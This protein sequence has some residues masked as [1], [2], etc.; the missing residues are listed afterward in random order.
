MTESFQMQALL[1][2]VGQAVIATDPAG[3]VTYWNPAAEA[4]YGWSADEALGCLVIDLVVPTQTQEEAAGVVAALAAGDSWSGDFPLRRKDGS[5]FHALVTDTPV[6]GVDGE[7][8]GI[9]GVSTDITARKAAEQQAR[10]LAAIVESCAD[11]I[12]SADLDGIITSWNQGAVDLYGCT[13]DEAIGKHVRQLAPPEL[14]SEVTSVLASAARGQTTSG[15]ET[16][17]WRKDGTRVDVSLTVSPVRDESGVV[18][19]S[20]AI[21]R[22]VSGCRALQ[23]DIERQVLYDRL[24]GLPNRAVLDD[25][26]SHAV[27]RSDGA[28]TA[29]AVMFVDLD[30]FKNLNNA[31]GHATGDLVLVEVAKRLTAAVRP[32]DT[33]ARFGGDEFVVICEGADAAVAERVAKRALEALH[34]PIEVDG[35][36]MYVTASVGI[37]TAPPLDAERL[38]RRADAAMYDAK[39]RGGARASLFDESLGERADEELTLSTDL[40]QAIELDQLHVHYQPIIELDTGNFIGVE[41]LARWEHPTMGSVPPDRFVR[42]AEHTGLIAELD[43]WVLRRAACDARTLLDHHL[44]PSNGRVAVNI[45]AHNVAGMELEQAVRSAVADAHVPYTAL[46]LEVT[47]TGVMVD[48]DRA[49]EVLTSLQALGVRTKIDDFGTGYSSFTYL[50]R[51]PVSAIKIDRAF[52]GEMLHDPDD[53]AIIVSIIDLARSVHVRTIAEGVET[54][55]QLVLLRRLGCWAAQGFLWSPA[56]PL[57]DLVRMLRTTRGGRFPVP[58]AHTPTGR[59]GRLLPEVTVEHG[60]SKLMQMRHDGASATTIAAAL[61]KDGFHTPQGHRWHS[62][63]VARAVADVADVVDANGARRVASV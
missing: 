16:V 27:H 31:A 8:I 23:R 33:I 56:V 22:D 35:D 10:R 2:A 54:A 60:L 52:I 37:A 11:A 63:S 3:R 19:G 45:S 21:V 9:I 6:Q 61:N 4:L 30:H 57:L 29:L 14:V 20:S 1:S 26:L 7:L 18:M 17:R 42:I 5:I 38:I 40:R 51:L 50:R 47:E 13:V 59:H 58:L 46:A 25:R 53:L 44:L 24:T 62:A 48:P 15:M 28:S 12:F 49:C 43:R 32:G 41:A 36:R 39:S 34:E 55:E